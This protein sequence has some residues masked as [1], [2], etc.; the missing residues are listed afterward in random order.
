MG[1]PPSSVNC[2][3][4]ALLRV[5]AEGG[6][7]MRVP[8]PA[9]GMMTTTFMTALKYTAGEVDC[10][11]MLGGYAGWTVRR[12]ER[13]CENIRENEGRQ[14]AESAQR[15][16]R[17]LGWGPIK[18]SGGLKRTLLSV[19][20]G[21]AAALVATG[22]SDSVVVPG[23]IRNLLSPGTE[24]ALKFVK[25]E[26]SH[27][28]AGAFLDALHASTEVMSFAF[29]A[30]AFFYTFFVFGVVT[31]FAGVKSVAGLGERRQR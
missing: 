28:G 1:V 19:V 20:L 29:I 3:E 30:N 24:L 14:V 27:R 8:S 18:V 11:F 2:F 21:V 7:A 4:G 10:K 9:A 25:A 13:L 15:L 31:T 17:V 22:I 23:A 16:S 12:L 26:G 6:A 5:L